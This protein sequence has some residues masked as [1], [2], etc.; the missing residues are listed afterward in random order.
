[1]LGVVVGSGCQIWDSDRQA[2]APP[3]ISV[4]EIGGG[5]RGTGFGGVVGSRCQIWDS[6][7]QAHTP[8]PISVLEIG[9]GRR[10][11]GLGFASEVGVRG[12]DKHMKMADNNYAWQILSPILFCKWIIHKRIQIASYILVRQCSQ[13]PS[14][15]AGC[16]DLQHFCSNRLE[17]GHKL[18]N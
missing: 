17:S 4:L 6:D 13:I 3:P 8:P 1:M 11:T 12:E 10:G 18:S 2:H 9:G 16:G 15:G 5:R 14:T 7:R